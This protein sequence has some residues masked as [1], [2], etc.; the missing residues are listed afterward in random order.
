MEKSI[1]INEM[2]G[3]HKKESWRNFILHLKKIL[4]RI[5]KDMKRWN[6]HSDLATL[7]SEKMKRRNDRPDFLM[8]LID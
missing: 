6:N 1:A 3:R 5:K 8:I 4:L 7:L 2:M